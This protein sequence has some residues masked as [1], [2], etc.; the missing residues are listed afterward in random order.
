MYFRCTIFKGLMGNFADGPQENFYR[1]FTAMMVIVSY[2]SGQMRLSG[3]FRPVPVNVLP[4][5]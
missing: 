4:R 1:V 3:P 2:D 5:W